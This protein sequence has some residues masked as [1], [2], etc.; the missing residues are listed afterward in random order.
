MQNE[1]KMKMK[2]K[3]ELSA[4][5]DECQASRRSLFRDSLEQVSGGDAENHRVTA[6]CKSCGREFSYIAP[7]GVKLENEPTLCRDCRKVTGGG[8]CR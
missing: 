7:D 6:V 5:K 1:R 2:T 3:E 4:P 8:R